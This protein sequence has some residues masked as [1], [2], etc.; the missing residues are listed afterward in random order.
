MAIRIRSYTSEKGYSDDFRNICDFLIRIN[1]KKVTTPNYLWARW[2]WQFGPYMSM[3]NLSHIGVAEDNGKII[4]LITYEH[5]LGEAYFCLDEEYSCLKPQLIDYAMA[6]LSSNG[7]LRITLPD[8]DLGYQ[9]A[10]VQRG[11]VATLH[12]SSVAR[13]DI[14]NVLYTLPEG[15]YI[16]SFDDERFD[17]DQYYSAIWKGF[18]NKRERNEIELESMKNR[19]GFDAPHLD[20]NLRILVIAPN[21]DYASHCGMSYIPGSE[22]AYVEPVFTL[23]EYR[24]MGLGKAAVLE[25]LKRCQKLGAK[26]AYVLSSQQFYYNI[27]FYPVQN[28]TW[29]ESKNN[30]Y[31]YSETDKEFH[32]NYKVECEVQILSLREHPERADEC[33]ELLLEHFNESTS[34]HPAQVLASS[35]IFPQGYFMLKDN[36]VIGWTGIHEKEVVSGKVYGWEGSLLQDEVLS[37]NLSPWITPLLIHPDERGNRYGK[38][39]LQHAQKEAGRLG[40]KFVYLTTGHIGY[41]EK[42]GFR[43]VGLTTFTW[44]RPTKVYEAE[45]TE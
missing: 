29:W 33:R 39:L 44:G 25:G 1:R 12:K 40:L 34:T 18:D 42:Y 23:P 20:L 4:A 8:G 6:N 17:A 43:E 5:D 35:G 37:E 24:K 38:L 27:G 21:G 14:D 13:I 2:E 32:R 31:I 9:Q 22:Y 36:K 45:V 16:M 19:E 26:Q 15:Y 28:E 11:F 10:A 41:Y 3:H 7:K 30:L